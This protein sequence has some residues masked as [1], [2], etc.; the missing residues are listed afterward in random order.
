MFGENYVNQSSVKPDVSIV[1]GLPGG[2]IGEVR[3][4]I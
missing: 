3:P 2:K 4:N 1:A